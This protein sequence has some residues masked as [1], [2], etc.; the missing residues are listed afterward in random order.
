[1]PKPVARVAL[2][3]KLPSAGSSGL[4]STA[5]SALPATPIA[6]RATAVALAIVAEATRAAA[7]VTL[8][9]TAAADIA[10]YMRPSLALIAPGPG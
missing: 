3:G 1:M 5:C 10:R 7:L 9:A 2:T 6:A 8:A 4:H